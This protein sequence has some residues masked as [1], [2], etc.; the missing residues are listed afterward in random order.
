[1]D[2]GAPRKTPEIQRDWHISSLAARLLYMSIA[3]EL[4]DC[5]SR[6]NAG[7]ESN[8]RVTS[9]PD[10]EKSHLQNE[11]CPPDFRFYSREGAIQEA[12]DWPFEKSRPKRR[13]FSLA[14]T[15]TLETSVKGTAEGRCPEPFPQLPHPDCNGKDILA[16]TSV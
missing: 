5:R 14:A 10:S 2:P 15:P 8:R 6:R 1:M 11:G 12:F 7:T 3:G 16:S 13:L 4:P 9:A